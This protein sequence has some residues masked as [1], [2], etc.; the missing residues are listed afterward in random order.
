VAQH[1]LAHPRWLSRP[2]AAILQAL[3]D[4]YP[5]D[6]GRQ[7]LSERAGQSATSSGFDKNLGALRTLG[8]IDYAPK[9]RAVALQVLFLE[10]NVQVGH[11]RIRRS[12]NIAL[13]L[14]VEI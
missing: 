12:R 13:A 5:N 8:L 7:E 3:I 4:I 11:T 9:G 6:I 10:E 2:Q 1:H 14:E